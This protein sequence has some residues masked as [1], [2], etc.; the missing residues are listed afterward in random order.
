MFESIGKVQG[1]G[2]SNSPIDYSFIDSKPYLGLGYYRLRQVDFDGT[3]ELFPIIQVTNDFKFKGI[4]VFTYPNPTT[5]E[6][7]NVRV[8]TGDDHSPLSLKIV[9][10]AGKSY[11]ETTF[12]G[13]LV[14]D[15]KLEPIKKMT[16][17]IYF[18]M[19]EQGRNIQRYKIII[20]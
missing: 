11:L 6:N 9:D 17:G 14:I 3:E 18:M 12:N 20:R 7:L 13:A 19:V 4:Q 16:S 2:N 1:N 10:M 8:I 15:E 5:A